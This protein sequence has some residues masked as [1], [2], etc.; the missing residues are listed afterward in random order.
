MSEK[1]INMIVLNDLSKE[2]IVIK[3]MPSEL[4]LLLDYDDAIKLA[5]KILDELQTDVSM[6]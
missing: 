1:Q 6:G 2:M 3:F 5:N 4:R